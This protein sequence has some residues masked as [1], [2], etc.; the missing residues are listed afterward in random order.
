MQGCV[1]VQSGEPERHFRLITEIYAG[2]KEMES[3]E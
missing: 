1:P 3:I 2:K